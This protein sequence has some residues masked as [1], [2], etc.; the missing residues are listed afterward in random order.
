[1][2]QKSYIVYGPQGCGKTRNAKAIAA[3]LGLKRVLDDWAPEPGR[4]IPTTDTL[5]LTYHNGPFAHS[6]RR[7]LSYTEAMARV[8]N[9]KAG[10]AK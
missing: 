3:A 9:G 1:M 10:G 5:V 4:P 6:P 7:V 8:K 2:S